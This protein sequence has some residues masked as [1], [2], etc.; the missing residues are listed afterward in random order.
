MVEDYLFRIFKKWTSKKS[1]VTID[2][3]KSLKNVSFMNKQ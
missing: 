1:V 2:F 3:K